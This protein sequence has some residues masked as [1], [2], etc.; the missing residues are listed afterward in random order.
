MSDELEPIAGGE[1][2]PDFTVDGTSIAPLPIEGIPELFSRPWLEGEQHLVC[3]PNGFGASVIRNRIGSYGGQK[4]LW[5]LAVIR[6]YSTDPPQWNVTYDT[7][8]TDDVLGWLGIQQV[9]EL[10][11]RISRL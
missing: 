1:M 2:L 3:F 6:V 7:P 10:L 8:I 9:A 4:G 5:E 11:L